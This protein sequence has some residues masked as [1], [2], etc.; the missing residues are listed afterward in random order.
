MI[1][2][3]DGYEANVKNRV[4]IGRYAYE[5]IWG[6]Y[7]SRKSKIDSFIIY[8]PDAPLSDLP[9]ETEWWMYR[10]AKPKR[11]WTVIGLP[12]AL[13]LTS[14]KPDIIFSPT[15]YIPRFTKVPRVMSVMDLSY[16]KFPEL[17]RAKDL[18]QLI[19]WT[20]YS[21]SHAKAIFTISQFSKNDI[22][23]TY[24]VEPKQVVVTYPGLNMAIKSKVENKYQISKHYILSVGTIQ[25]RKNYTRLIAAF[26][27]FL[28]LN[29]QRFG[30][31]DLVIVGKKGWMVE[32]IL[33]APKTYHVENRV[34]FLDFVPDGDL[35]ALYHGALCFALPSLYEGFGL[36]VLEAMAQGCPVVVSH[37]SSLP[38][39]A[40]EAGVYVDPT[41]VES[42][43]K[44][45]LTA[46]RQRN[47]MQGKIRVKKGL[48]Q[49]KKF[50]WDTAAKQTLEVLTQI[51]KGRTS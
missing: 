40:G 45:L 14:P 22:I 43:T 29:K 34:K 21:V 51:G 3:I 46:V 24:R 2:A 41:S 19:H 31:I 23:K 5:I 16:L 39:I 25:P 20:K 7:N 4:G 1:V 33:E 32:D 11:F 18:H 17:F 44:G 28:K 6:I 42:I 47:L 15:H 49:V 37:V 13:W 8:L 27:E 10:I 36:P 48:E 9:T 50:S 26:S 12:L 30:E 35:P 38:E